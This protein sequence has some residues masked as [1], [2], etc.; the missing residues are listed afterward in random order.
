MITLAMILAVAAVALEL[1]NRVAGQ[2][3][4][5]DW[6]EFADHGEVLTFEQLVSID[7]TREAA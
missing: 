1:G 3:Q 6:S 4:A 5:S 2:R 7:V